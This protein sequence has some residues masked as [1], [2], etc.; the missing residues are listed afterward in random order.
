[1]ITSA[2]CQS[3]ASVAGSRLRKKKFT[4]A[5]VACPTTQFSPKQSHPIFF[6]LDADSDIPSSGSS[7]IHLFLAAFGCACCF[8]V[9]N[10]PSGGNWSF[11]AHRTEHYINV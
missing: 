6:I 11:A 2:A 4:I 8:I 3:A 1:M 5:I 10:G 7:R 9:A